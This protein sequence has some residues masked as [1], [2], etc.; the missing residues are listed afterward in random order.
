MFY[1][2]R[3]IYGVGMFL[4]FVAF[5]EDS[6]PYEDCVVGVL[7]PSYALYDDTIGNVASFHLQGI[8]VGERSD[9]MLRCACTPTQ[10][11]DSEE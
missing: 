7:N 4:D 10:Q 2:L 5:F 3:A 9:F 1:L 6:I 8:G 11:H